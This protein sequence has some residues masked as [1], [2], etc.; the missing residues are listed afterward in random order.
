MKDKK[1]IPGWKDICG[2]RIGYMLTAN[3]HFA[4]QVRQGLNIWNLNGFA[5]TFLVH[6][7]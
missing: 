3:E 6:A 7:P 2:L 1:K 4:D 5:E